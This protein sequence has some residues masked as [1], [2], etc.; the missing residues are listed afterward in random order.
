MVDL[1][2][3]S[4][5]VC[6]I[7]FCLPR[8]HQNALERNGRDFHCP[9]GH[10][11]SYRPT[12]DQKRIAELEKEVARW[13]SQWRRRQ[14][15][16]DEVMAQR[17]DLIAALKECPGGCGWRSR[18]Q[19]QRDPVAMGRGIERVRRDVAEHLVEAHGCRPIEA[20]RLLPERT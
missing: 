13:D 18:R 9:N 1:V 20:Q 10:V 17:E 19:V 7:P 2:N 3:V 16:F 15:A 4:C 14:R 12:A 11:I 8:T 6:G 5:G